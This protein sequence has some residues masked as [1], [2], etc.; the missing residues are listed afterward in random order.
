[1]CPI[2]LIAQIG[3]Q[4]PGALRQIPSLLGLVGFTFDPDQSIEQSVRPELGK[5]FAY[6]PQEG[7][8]AAGR[9]EDPLV[10]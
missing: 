7:A 4:D 3:S 10:H 6:R 5:A 9:F 8:I 1:M 2:G